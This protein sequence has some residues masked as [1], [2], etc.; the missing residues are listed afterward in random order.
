[1]PWQEELRQS[2]YRGVPFVT[3]R[4]ALLAGKRVQVHEYLGRDEAFVE[5]LGA[6]ARA[7]SLECYVHG[8]DYLLQASLLEDALQTP[9]AG[10]FVDTY[11][12][13]LTV[14]AVRY[15]VEQGS[16]TPGGG[17]AQFSIEFVETALN[18]FPTATPRTG[19][20]VTTAADQA[21]S[22]AAGSFERVFS[23]LDEVQWVVEDAETVVEMTAGAIAVLSVALPAGGTDLAT[24]V[25]HL[26]RMASTAK[27]L[28]TEPGSLASNV[29]EA[30]SRLASLAGPASA[31]LDALERAGK[32]GAELIPVDETTQ[33]RAAQARNRAA[34]VHIVRRAAAL[35]AAKV[36]ARA[37]FASYED[38]V[39]L[40]DRVVSLID[41]QAES[42]GE[43]GDDEAFRAMR[44]LA[45]AVIQDITARGAQ[46]AR[47]T[48]FTPPATMPALVISDRLYGDTTRADEIIARNRI[49]HPGFVPGG[50][51]LQILVP[52]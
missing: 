12:G 13:E 26:G 7:F 39:A 37:A 5:E 21:S 3:G 23:V 34:Q 22:A 16:V 50:R 33:A 36:S 51:A 32:Y 1:V 31:M 45:T 30:M 25:Q 2:S 52:A 44:N 29:L 11:R 35:E 17:I 15:T 4:S 46:L 47:L 18:T 49:A 9:G 48:T 6:A 28:V 24:F 10:L 14:V 38:A 27:D 40:R 19:A 20:V 42:A 43:L 8:P 41:D